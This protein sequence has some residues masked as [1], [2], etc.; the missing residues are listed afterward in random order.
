MSSRP[1]KRGRSVKAARHIRIFHWM[2]ATEAWKSLDAVARAA[3][4]ELASIYAGVG[5]NNGRI[6]FS[7]R[8]CATAL[9]VGKSTAARALADLQDRGF[10]VC[11]QRG[12][13]AWKR[14]HATTWRLT[15]F[16]CDVTDSVPSKEFAR[17]G[18]N[19]SSQPDQTVADA[20]QDGPCNRTMNAKKQADGISDETVNP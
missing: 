17:W 3:Y 4:I 7:V 10:I 11:M 6:A 14:R 1:H 12:G 20:G 5:S 18:K 15:E 19:Q 2:L 13:F 8:K 9:H 16:P